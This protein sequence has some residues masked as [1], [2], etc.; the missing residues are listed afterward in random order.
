MTDSEL[1]SFVG[2]MITTAL[3]NGVSVLGAVDVVQKDSPTQQGTNS[4]PTAYF[5]RVFD[6]GRGMPI[7]KNEYSPDTG[8]MTETTVRLTETTIQISALSWQDPTNPVVVTAADIVQYINTYF[9][10]PSVRAVFLKNGLNM[11]KVTDVRNPWFEN[12][13]NQFEAMPN[14]DFVL[15]HQRSISLVIDSIKSA[16]GVV[17]AVP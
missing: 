12:D 14:F 4:A 6:I 8:L 5:E 17:T 11:L 1:L 9:Q 15:T 2:Q 13:R 10:A 7:V 16:N 3:L